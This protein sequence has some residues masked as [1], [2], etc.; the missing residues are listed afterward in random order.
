MEEENLPVLSETNQ[1]QSWNVT[2]CV[3][4]VAKLQVFVKLDCAGRWI[5]IRQSGLQSGTHIFL[6]FV[7]AEVTVPVPDNGLYFLA[8]SE[9]SLAI[10]CLQSRAI[11]TDPVLT[12]SILEFQEMVHS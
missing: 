4:S 8:S 1:T 9:P 5:I 7:S 2:D 12:F 3:G 11:S 10:A 6:P